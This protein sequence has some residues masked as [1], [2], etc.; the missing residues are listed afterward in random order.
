MS[1]LLAL[2]LLIGCSKSP[3][4]PPAA[5]VSVE[6]AP[7][8]LS[9]FQA[10]LMGTPWNI[11]IADAKPRE[12]LNAAVNAAFREVERVEGLMSEWR[13]SSAISAINAAAGKAPVQVPAEVRDLIARALD[14]ARKSDG[15]FDPTWAALRGVW[16][17]KSDPPRLPLRSALDAATARID[18]RKVK[19]ADDTVFLE[20]PG[21]A[22]GLGGIAKGYGIDRAVAVLRSHGLERFIVDGGGDLFIA[23]EKQPGVPWTIGLRHPRGGALIGELAVRDVAVVTSG[24]YE[25]FF[26]LGGRR[27]HHIIDVR[28]G[29]PANK[30]VAVSI[31]AP[32]ATIADAWATGAFVLGPAALEKLAGVS[33]AIFTPDGR[34]HRNGRFAG[35]KDRWR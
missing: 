16:D 17:F 21:M 4:P 24:D 6:P 29:M 1:R 32:N 14:I 2:A 8:A 35:L 27:Y 31:L 18:Y 30:S 5:P 34:I 25:R 20:A 13:P 3:E 33:V 9:R 12:A 19:I 28:T 10:Q 7:V 23:G 15:A 22:L 11:T 26:E